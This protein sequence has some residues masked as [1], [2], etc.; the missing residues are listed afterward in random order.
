MKKR[1]IS[2][3]LAL[4]L[5]VGLLPLSASAHP[6]RDVSRSSWYNDAVE[7]VY[8]EGIFGGVASGRFSPDSSMT[9]AAVCAGAGE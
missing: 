6:F 7:Y 3:A 1:L 5:C 2:M 8:G 4:L 9:R